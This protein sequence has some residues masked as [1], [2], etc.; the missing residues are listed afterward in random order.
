MLRIHAQGTAAFRC[1]LATLLAGCTSSGTPAA[2]ATGPEPVNPTPPAPVVETGPVANHDPDAGIFTSGQANRGR[3]AFD[4]ACSDCHTNSEFRGRAFQSDWGR[5]T[6]YSF[7]RTVRSTMP[8]DNPGA[9]EEETY[10]DVV[11]YI[12]SINGHSSGSSELAAD[13]PMREV[14]LAP[15]GVDR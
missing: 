2:S 14:R 15:P 1:A 7:Y 4:E 10:L 3:T 8:D 11:S 5:R 6:V 13:S 12:L 9:L